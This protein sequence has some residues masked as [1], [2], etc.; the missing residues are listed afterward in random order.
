MSSAFS[1]IVQTEE[2]KEQQY[3]IGNVMNEMPCDQSASLIHLDDAWARPKRNDEYSEDSVM[4]VNYPTHPFD[5]NGLS[6]TSVIDLCWETLEEG[7]WLIMDVDDWLLPRV[8]NYLINEYG[9]VNGGDK[10]YRGGGYRKTGR[11]V[12]VTKSDGTV[13]RAGGAKY[14]RQS[15]YPVVF[16]HKGETDRYGYSSVVQLCHKPSDD[17]GWYSLKP[18]PPYKTWI[19]EL[20]EEGD[21]I[22]EPCAGTAPACIAARDLYGDNISFTAIDVEPDASKAFHRRMESFWFNGKDISNK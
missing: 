15:G 12:Y 10:P 8:T 20:T 3:I 16:A 4:G 11:V 5:G 1:D 13:N 14:L 7:G 2:D 21:T 17:H 6:V 9:D 19:D 22:V 18:I